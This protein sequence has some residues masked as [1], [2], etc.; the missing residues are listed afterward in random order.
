[1][2]DLLYSPS[3]IFPAIFLL[4]PRL[5]TVFSLLFTTLAL[6]ALALSKSLPA[7]TLGQL[8]L[9]TWLCQALHRSGPFRLRK[10]PRGARA[11]S[12]HSEHLRHH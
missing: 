5:V 7:K 8:P 1:M 11:N 6:P 4:P 2:V 9:G 10:L 12:C 3:T